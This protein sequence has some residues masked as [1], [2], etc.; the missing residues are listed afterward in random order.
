MRPS[1]A[2]VSS[3]L[4]SSLCSVKSLQRNNGSVAIY[5]FDYVIVGGGTVRFFSR[6]M[7]GLSGLRVG[8]FGFGQPAER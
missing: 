4:L 3:I 1:F 6:K 8:R 2:L 7:L 5:E